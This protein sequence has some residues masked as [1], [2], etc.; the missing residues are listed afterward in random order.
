VRL[1]SYINL[2]LDTELLGQD[3]RYTVLSQYV[4]LSYLARD[5]KSILHS[6]SVPGNLSSVVVIG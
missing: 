5:I 6:L 3:G 2:E 4:L 1:L